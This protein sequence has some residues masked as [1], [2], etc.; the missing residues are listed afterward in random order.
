MELKVGDVVNFKVKGIPHT[1]G[2]ITHKEEGIIYPIEVL[3]E[4]FG[5]YPI[6]IEEITPNFKDVCKRVLNEI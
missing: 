4:G 1:S 6:A 2:T 3:I 5:Y